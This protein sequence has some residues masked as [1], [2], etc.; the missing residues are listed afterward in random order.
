MDYADLWRFC[1]NREYPEYECTVVT[2][3]ETDSPKYYGACI[4]YLMENPNSNICEYTYITDIDMLILREDTP[5]HEY[6]TKEMRN[7]ECFSNARRGPG[8]PQGVNRLTGLHFMHK[9]WYEKTVDARIKYTEKLINKEIGSVSIDDELM[10]AKIVTESG[11]ELPPNRPL[12]ERHHGIHLGTLRDKSKF[13]NSSA[14][15]QERNRAFR[16]RVNH[17]M[18][19]RWVN[20]IDSDE[21]KELFKNMNMR[22]KQ[23]IWELSEVERLCRQMV[24]ERVG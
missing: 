5:I 1:I 10:L 2:G 4:R 18:A 17:N 3:T 8:E 7:G 13:K 22:N 24:N 19:K 20:I 16:A 21:Y 14:S 12:I 9:S 23:L 11:M 15:L 6:H